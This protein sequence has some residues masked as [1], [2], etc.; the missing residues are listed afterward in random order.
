MCACYVAFLTRSQF[1]GDD[2]GRRALSGHAFDA[3]MLLSFL[4]HFNCVID[5]RRF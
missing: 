4:S 3:G 1:M 2:D 5:T